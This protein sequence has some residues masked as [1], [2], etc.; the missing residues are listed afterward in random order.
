M[1]LQYHVY[2][3]WLGKVLLAA[4]PAGLCSLI[5]AD[6]VSAAELEL[7]QTFRRHSVSPGEH[8]WFIQAL[9]YIETPTLPLTLPLDLHG[10]PFQLAVWQA[11]VRIPAGQT[12][13]YAE[14]ARQINKPTAFRAVARACGANPLAILVPC[15]RVIGSNGSLTGYSGG[16]WRKR[17]LLQR[18]GSLPV[19]E[20]T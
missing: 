14:L 11:L 15:H 6:E 9:Q 10:T 2:D 4:S 13:S 5:L 17:A 7:T 12:R 1:K 19:S 18:E 20:N 3:S 8:P 16:L